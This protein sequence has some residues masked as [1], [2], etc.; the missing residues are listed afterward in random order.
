MVD[1]Q[2][3]PA[4][5]GPVQPRRD[6]ARERLAAA[7]REN[8]HRRKAQVRARR[9]TPEPGQDPAGESAPEPVDACRT[10]DTEVEKR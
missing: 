9:A 10:R 8:L 7:L 3:P 1:K 2:E 6:P 4:A 5:A